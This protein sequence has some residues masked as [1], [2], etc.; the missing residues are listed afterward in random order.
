[1]VG[2]VDGFESLHAFVHV[3]KIFKFT[4]AYAWHQ[5]HKRDSTTGSS[6][7]KYAN[8]TASTSS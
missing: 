6:G 3:F 1:M 4:I 5:Y 8:L 2:T 7:G